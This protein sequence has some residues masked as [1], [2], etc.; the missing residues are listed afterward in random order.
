MGKRGNSTFGKKELT[1]VNLVKDSDF[2]WVVVLEST[3]FA[4]LC[5]QKIVVVI[6][7][8]VVIDFFDYECDYDSDHEHRQKIV[9]RGALAPSVP[10]L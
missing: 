9:E 8:V 6:V 1:F 7:I 4:R 10:M 2:Q 5:W 3:S